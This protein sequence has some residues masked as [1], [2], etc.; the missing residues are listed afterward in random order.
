LLVTEYLS[1]KTHTCGTKHYFV[2]TN[3]LYS[4]EAC[5]EAYNC[6]Y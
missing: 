2:L 1:L 5:M 6:N 4:D 3:D